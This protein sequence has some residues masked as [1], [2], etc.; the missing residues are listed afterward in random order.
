MTR[1]EFET[2]TLRAKVMK[3]TESEREGFWE[4]YARGLQRGHYGEKFGTKEE[5]KT[6]WRLAEDEADQELGYGYRAGY[7]H[8]TMG[9]AYCSHNDF[10]CETC[11]LVNYGLDCNNLPVDHE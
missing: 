11:S 10:S 2:E 5:H 9:G 8:A 3:T 4:G 6:W 1:K 7:R